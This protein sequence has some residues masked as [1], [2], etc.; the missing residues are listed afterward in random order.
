MLKGRIE[1]Q[2]FGIRQSAV[3]IRHS[4]FGIRH[5]DAG[6]CY[7]SPAMTSLSLTRRAFLALAGTLPLA[8]A[9]AQTRRPAVGLE[10]FSVRGDLAKDLMATVRTVAKMGYE[11]VEFFSP[12]YSW[13]PEYAKEV[14]TLLDDLGIRCPSTHNSAAALTADGLPKAIELNQLLGSRYIVMA[15]PPR[16]TNLDGW[17]ALADTLSAASERLQP[18][19][20]FAGFHNHA[21]E[22]AVVEG[23]RPIDVIANGTPKHF[24]LQLDVGT[25]VAAGADPVAFI[26]AHPG[27]ITSVHC[28]DWAPGSPKEEKGYRVLF[29]EGA[30]PWPQIFKAA[31]SIGGVEHYLLEQEG[32]RF[33]EFETAQRCLDNW[34]K[35]RG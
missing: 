1:A 16:I 17:K 34:R 15:S 9:L 22:W 14:R 21:S 11:V 3:G 26:N 28:K 24:T 31:E 25:C 29:G 4:A 27:R 20:M 33:P 23:V 30:S 12:Y 18:L 2:F 7:V 19:G 35:M 10:L 5:S 8:P 13:T 32:S 6:A